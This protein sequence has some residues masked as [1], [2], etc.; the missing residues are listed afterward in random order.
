MTYACMTPDELALWRNNVY[1]PAKS[2]CIDC[3][4]EFRRAELLAGRCCQALPKEPPVE[5]ARAANGRLLDVQ[6]EANRE[7]MRRQRLG[8]SPARLGGVQS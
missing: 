1:A 7:Y 8:Y 4:L 6:R 5:G 3:P 2:P